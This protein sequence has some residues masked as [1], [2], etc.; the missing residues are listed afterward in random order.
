[1]S[2][3]S[4][5]SHDAEVIGQNPALAQLQGQLKANQAEIANREHHIAE[6]QQRINDYQGRLNAAPATEQGLT[7]LTRGYNQSKS[8]YD[9]LLKKK[10]ESEMA[11][12]MELLKQ[13]ERFTVLD[14]P[15][16]PTA[17]S[18]PNHLKF[19]GIGLGV[20][21]VL[22]VI[23]AGGFEFADD[24]LHSEKELKGLLPMTILSEIPEVV[25]PA[26]EAKKKR[27]LVLNWV[28]TV[29]VLA[30]VLTGATISFLKG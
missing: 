12:S 14:P 10:N 24:R 13:G 5:P 7:E 30:V 19:C 2:D 6:L 1:M 18:F 15:S 28:A 17:P 4:T 25:Q 8:D 21:L 3:S 29:L 9:E 27:E 11:T 23:V 22:G 20:G 26:D 16:L